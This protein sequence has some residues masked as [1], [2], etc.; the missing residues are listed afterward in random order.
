M[1][2]RAQKMS[3][4]TEVPAQALVRALGQAQVEEGIL[5][6]DAIVPHRYAPLYHEVLAD[7]KI[8]GIIKSISPDY[9]LELARRL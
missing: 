1:S 4:Q 8:K 3:A 9:S 5:P 2:A 7:S 6:P